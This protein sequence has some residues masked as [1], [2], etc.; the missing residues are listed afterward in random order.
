MDIWI[1]VEDDGRVL[2]HSIDL[3]PYGNKAIKYVS[4]FSNE[5][6][7]GRDLF[8]I[9]KVPGGQNWSSIG[10]TGYTPAEFHLLKYL[11]EVRAKFMLYEMFHSWNVQGY[12]GQEGAIRLNLFLNNQKHNIDAH[13]VEEE[14]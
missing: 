6:L 4:H 5:G 9:I 3:G 10:E 2:T 7:S 1:K 11:G 14:A 8:L 12:K 13:S